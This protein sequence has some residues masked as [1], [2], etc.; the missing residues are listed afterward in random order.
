MVDPYTVKF[1]LKE[2]YVWLLSVLAYPTSMWIIAPEVVQH[3]GD[4]KQP[5]TA[6]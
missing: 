5:E 3:F 1:V 4:L 2:P 6:S